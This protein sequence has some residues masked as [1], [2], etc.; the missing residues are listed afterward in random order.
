[1]VFANGTSFSSPTVAG[2]AAVLRAKHPTRNARQIRNALHAAANETA[3]G[4]DSA[5]ID[6]GNGLLDVAAADALLAHGHV[7]SRIPDVDSGRRHDHDDELGAGGN[8]VQLN[9]LK[10]GQR[11][12]QFRNNSFST[13]VS[14]LKPGEVAQIFVPSDWFTS[15]LTVTIDQVLPALPPGSQNQLFGDDI[16]YM[17]ADAPTSFLVERASGFV[18]T[19]ATHVIDHPQTGLVRVAL[20]GDWTNAGK[21]SARVTV[22]RERSPGLPSSLSIIEQDE[23]D[24]YE[25]EVPSASTEAVFELA[26][27]Q[28]WSRYPTNDLDLLLI[29]PSGV[30][31]QAGATLSSPERVRVANPASG[32]WT[33]AVVG[34]SI[35]GKFGRDLYTLRAEADGKRLKRQ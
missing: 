31:S 8:S 18:A 5:S 27:K 26:W 15:R 7:S 13:T 29:D 14:R 30:V 32:R 3:L 34:F 2:G 35:N 28:N 1:V 24:L 25:F 11:I 19:T 33:V 21:V 23:V 22:T 16:F 6:Q 20:Q 9:V 17:V 4:D 10:A 12:A